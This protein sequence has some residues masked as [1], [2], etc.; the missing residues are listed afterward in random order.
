MTAKSDNAARGL[1]DVV[2]LAHLGRY[3]MGDAALEMELLGMFDGQLADI[4][5]AL[6]RAGEDEEA[7]RLAAHTLKGAARAIGAFAL[8]E[9][10]QAL[11][12][13]GPGA[14]RSLREELHRRAQ[15]FHRAWQD[16]R[17]IH[18]EPGCATG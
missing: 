6:E 4:A 9:T 12:E 10:A 8:A 17:R 15:A 14:P 11:E 13:A 1:G 2:D 5:S 18:E 3:T 7:W 16:W